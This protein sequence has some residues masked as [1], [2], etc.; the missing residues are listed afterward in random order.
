M[1]VVVVSDVRHESSSLEHVPTCEWTTARAAYLRVRTV[2]SAVAVSQRRCLWLSV[3]LVR[4]SQTSEAAL[5]YVC[6]CGQT[7][8][9]DNEKVLMLSSSQQDTTL[10]P[11]LVIVRA[12]RH[13]PTVNVAE[14]AKPHRSPSSRY[15]D[16]SHDSTSNNNNYTPS[17]ATRS[18]GSI[19]SSLVMCGRVSSRRRVE[20]W[21]NHIQQQ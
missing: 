1:N 20:R 15:R 14:P 8:I 21:N 11:N 2:A 12:H 9:D 10:V 19:N 7:T 4:T 16:I 13:A 5:R 18:G 3:N 6:A 17:L